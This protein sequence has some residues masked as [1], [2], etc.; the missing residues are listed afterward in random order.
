MLRRPLLQ[1]SQDRPL[2][3]LVDEI[4]WADEEFEAYLKL[5]VLSEFQITAIP[6]LGTVESEIDP[7]VV[8]DLERH[9]AEQSDAP[10]RRRST[11]VDY[12]AEDKELRILTARVPGIEQALAGQIVRFV[13]LCGKEELKKA[14][15]IAETLDWARAW[16]GWMSPT[17]ATIPRRCRRAC[18]AC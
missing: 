12:P 16:S 5:E 2:V 4:D 18:C 11:Y 8:L 10:R 6:E 15:G 17:C 14:P 13:Q 3:L 7:H 9:R 1:I